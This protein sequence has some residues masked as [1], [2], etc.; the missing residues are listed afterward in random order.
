M[1]YE[2][3]FAFWSSNPLVLLAAGAI[4]TSLI[5]PYV[6][7]RWEDRKKTLEIKVK[8]ITKMTET[9]ATA[10]AKSPILSNQ[11]L[12]SRKQKW[13]DFHE[14]FL[15]PWLK[16]ALKIKAELKAYTN[17]LLED[18]WDNLL[19]TLFLYVNLSYHFRFLPD[20]MP[21]VQN[22]IS[23]LINRLERI[24]GKDM[25]EIEGIISGQDT[26][27]W[28]KIGGILFSHADKLMKQVIDSNI[29]AFDEPLLS[30]KKFRT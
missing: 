16:E 7:R 3:A 19:N 1:G 30:F 9:V 5:F 13:D 6:T 10:L 20:D 29:S 12:E 28:E 4:A 8:I 22:D 25:P 27:R 14:D 11:T 21:K 2:E 23:S 17:G 24:T 26:E 18:D 15:L